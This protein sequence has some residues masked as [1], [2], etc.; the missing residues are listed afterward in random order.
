MTAALLDV[1]AL[2]L[3]ALWVGIAIVTAM[4]LFVIVERLSLAAHERS[5]RKLKR[6]YGPVI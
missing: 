1:H 5:L 2:A 3:W 4:A 6:L